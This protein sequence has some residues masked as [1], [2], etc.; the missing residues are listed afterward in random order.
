MKNGT[1]IKNGV[2]VDGTG[3]PWYRAD[4]AIVGDTIAEIESKDG[5]RADK[6]IDA[7][8][9]IVAPGFID[10]HG[11]ADEHLIADNRAESVIRQGITTVCGGNCGYT[12]F[13][14]TDFNR[15]FLS[16]RVP[17]PAKLTWATMA[18]FYD[19]VQA[20]GVAVNLAMLVGH[21]AIRSAVM[22]FR[23]RKPTAAELES[24][25]ELLSK[26]MDDGAYGMSSGLEYPP[27][28]FASTDELIELSKIVAGKGGFYSSHTR[29]GELNYV[30][31]V[32]ELIKIGREANVPVQNSHIESHFPDWG[33]T[34]EVLELVDTARREGID[35]TC[36]IPPYLFGMT[37][38]ATIIPKRFHDGGI[39]ELRDRLRNQASR[40]QIR[41][42]ILN[43]NV[44]D[45]EVVTMAMAVEEMWDDIHVS[46]RDL[47]GSIA[48]K[49]IAE[50]SN[51]QHKPP[52]EV[53]FDLIAESDVDL[54]TVYR[55]HN[56]D[57]IQKI[58]RH[59][60]SMIEC[61]ARSFAV[62]GPLSHY[63]PHPRAFG[64]FPLVLRKYVR[65]ETLAN[66]PEE[67]GTKLLSL[68][69]AINKMT[70]LPARRLGLPDRGMIKTGIK[71]DVVI[72]DPD[73]ITDRATYNKPMAYPEGI[74][75]VF[76]NGEIAI[77][78][79]ANTGVLSGKTLKK[80]KLP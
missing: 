38:L 78:D 51:A 23:E 20:N 9:M 69:T 68:E 21:G 2:V 14:V 50:I 7:T 40:D 48:G 6:I 36:D 25:K 54:F 55:G 76:V 80:G 56:E 66:L 60:T 62:D 5:I 63:L 13:P 26:A 32:K 11:H 29:C 61:D 73:K 43:M 44:E 45:T 18:E 67:P 37:T 12:S 64:T 1:L 31:A 53:V 41:E 10:I 72:F 33:K 74:R 24:M 27:G 42:T 8:D 58:L 16:E 30:G 79:G 59:P 34:T 52:L 3:G 46:G 15:E 28:F 70:L 39:G 77:D 19:T 47:D 49:T 35:V 4:V 65:G 75:F 57:D 22:G 17:E 71:A